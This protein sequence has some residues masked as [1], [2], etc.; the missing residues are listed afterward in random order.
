MGF[1]A[2]EKHVMTY[3]RMVGAKIDFFWRKEKYSEEGVIARRDIYKVSALE[4]KDGRVDRD[5]CAL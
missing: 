3:P 5:T 2:V 4:H 1:S